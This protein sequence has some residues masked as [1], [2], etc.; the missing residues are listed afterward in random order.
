MLAKVDMAGFAC[1]A[2]QITQTLVANNLE[3]AKQEIDRSSTDDGH[4]Q[5]KVENHFRV[6]KHSKKFPRSLEM[7]LLVFG[8]TRS[9]Q[10]SM[11]NPSAEPMNLPKPNH[12]Q[13]GSIH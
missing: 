9:D 1:L 3:N 12:M 8:S 2:F 13:P 10:F 7:K 11:G 4:K 6:Q 5:G